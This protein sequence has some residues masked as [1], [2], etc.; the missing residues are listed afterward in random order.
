VLVR[1]SPAILVLTGASGAGKTTLIKD[2]EAM[3]VSGIACFNCDVIY[4][5]LPEE[6][7]KDGLI[8]QDAILSHWVSHVLDH[9]EIEV[10]VLDTQIRPHRARALL[11]KREL[12]T[13]Q[14][15]LVECEQY[16]RTM[17]LHGPRGQP[18]LD[19]TQME[20]WAAY[21]RG[22]ADALGLESINTSGVDSSASVAQL[23][24]LA[25]DLRARRD[26]ALARHNKR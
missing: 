9:N 12:A 26:A 1:Y 3:Q 13:T 23:L 5:D 4:H 25:E 19:T 2:L 17:R 14:I 11:S 24:K 7:R 10:A 16:E 15:V 21:L 18:E 20:N 22:Q 6:I 8:A